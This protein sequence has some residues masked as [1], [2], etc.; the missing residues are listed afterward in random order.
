MLGFIAKTLLECFKNVSLDV[1]LVELALMFGVF[2]HLVA[3]VFVKTLFFTLNVAIYTVEVT[4]LF[5]V[6]RLDFSKLIA[7]G[8]QTFDFR[9]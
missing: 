8:A 1:V 2:A 4:L 7:E 3:H 6:V 5:V 9:S